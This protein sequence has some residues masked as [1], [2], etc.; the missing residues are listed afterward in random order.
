MAEM[1]TTRAL[2][3]T[4]REDLL[5]IGYRMDFVES[6]NSMLLWYS[7][8]QRIWNELTPFPKLGSIIGIH[9]G[10]EYRTSLRENEESLFSDVPHDGFAQGLRRVTDDFEPYV[11][12]ASTYLNMN[13][14]LMLYEAYKL[15][16]DR[17]KI[18]AN[19]AR[20]SRGRWLIA[21]AIDEQGLVC[22]QR[23]HGIW[24][25]GSVPLEVIAALVNSPV[26]NALLSTH[27]TSRDNQ[28]RILQQVPIPNFTQSQMR[29]IV[30]LVREYMA[31]RE[32]WRHQPDNSRYLESSA[33]GIMRQI[34]AEL[35]R[36]YNLPIEL[37]RELVNY[38]AG[39]KR[40]GPISLTQIKPSPEKRF[41]TSII[42]IEGVRNEGNDKV[43]DAVV[44]S[45]NPHQIVQF[46]ISFIPQHLQDKL[47]LDIRL[48]ARVNIG[49]ETA[50]DLI[51]EEIEL[52]PESEINGR[53][54]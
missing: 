43:V 7:H 17:P 19:A 22:T 28:I 21:G 2:L 35:L 49:A 34:D 52:A 38:F 6:E 14:Q 9:R 13:P 25:K 11:T 16:W 24:S 42:R 29:L 1:Y 27:R 20:L 36:A 23:Y 54:A 10:V 51:F 18:I 4:M 41:Y 48:L 8:L 44:I 53:L 26:T 32:Q 5:N 40:P 37:E 39:Y 45:W 50:E 46:P 33:R 3:G 12:K 15:P 47:T 31:I 30:S